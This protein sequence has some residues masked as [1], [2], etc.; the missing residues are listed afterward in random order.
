MRTCLYS[1]EAVRKLRASEAA[2]LPRPST[3]AQSEDLHQERSSRPAWGQ[4][5]DPQGFLTTLC[6]FLPNA[7]YCLHYRLV[8]ALG[9]VDGELW[10]EGKE[11]HVSEPPEGSSPR[12]SSGPP[13]KTG[14]RA[15]EQQ[16]IFVE[17]PSGNRKTSQ[18]KTSCL[19]QYL[20]LL[21]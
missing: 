2:D 4:R 8:S 3:V 20:R 6:R 10:A 16:A 12:L 9:P 17:V 21:G 13:P 5:A 18:Q 1:F 19:A 14:L 15:A 11:E 7:F